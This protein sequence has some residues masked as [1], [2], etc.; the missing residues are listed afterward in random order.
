MK[1]TK[2]LVLQRVEDILQI[3]LDGAQFWNIRQYISEQYSKQGSPWSLPEGCP[4]LV[5]RTLWWYIQRADKMIAESCN[6]SRD[7]IINRNIA[8]RRYLYARAVAVA[9]YRTALAAL[10]EEAELLGLYPERTVPA[11]GD[12]VLRVTRV[13]INVGVDGKAATN[14]P[15]ESME[16][17]GHAEGSEG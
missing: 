12:T 5:D 13:V 7:K 15:S 1:A 8:Q 11:D 14:E 10:R 2:A 16:R 3:R 9:D 17:I 6:E 4:P